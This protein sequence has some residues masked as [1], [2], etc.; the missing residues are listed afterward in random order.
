MNTHAVVPDYV[1]GDVGGMFD[2]VVRGLVGG[3]VRGLWWR[4][5]RVND[6]S[7]AKHKDLRS[8]IRHPNF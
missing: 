1:G 8:K 5:D 7:V 6:Q 3:D 4:W 2:G